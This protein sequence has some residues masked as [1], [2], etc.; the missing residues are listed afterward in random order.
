MNRFGFCAKTAL[1]GNCEHGDLG[2]WLLPANYSWQQAATHCQR[3]CSL[4]SRCEYVSYSR[5]HRDCSWFAKCDLNSLRTDVAGFRTSRAT[6]LKVRPL[7]RLQ[8][9]PN[10]IFIP[11]LRRKTF[12]GPPLVVQVGANDHSKQDDDPA[13]AAIQL[14]WRAILIEPIPSMFERLAARY[15]KLASRSPGRLR[16]ENG[17]I[18]D[19]C[20]R[21]TMPIHSIDAS[22]RSAGWGSQHA[23]PRCI[24]PE[25]A[26]VA[27]LSSFSRQHL[28]N[29]QPLLATNLSA[30]CTACSARVGRALP[31]TC[32]SRVIEANIVQLPA[33]CV[34]LRRELQHEV[35]VDLLVVDAEGFD[36]AVLAQYPFAEVPTSRVIFESFHLD[37]EQFEAA[38]RVL[39]GHGFHHVSGKRRDY[40]H[41]YHNAGLAPGYQDAGAT[42]A[43]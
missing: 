11:S 41:T 10:E 25:Q 42:P 1:Y 29:H 26:W 36:A 20:A 34:C 30:E 13:R 38:T 43:S 2:H 27:E 7:S 33:R 28:L 40:F 19:S 22:S 24:G 4:C 37:D 12:A 3:Q 32:M 18:C 9:M 8:S 31:P 6:L 35:H 21:D 5:V 17:A 39:R 14:G 23:D 16:L 15:A